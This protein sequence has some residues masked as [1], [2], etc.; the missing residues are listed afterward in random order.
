[1]LLIAD[2]LISHSL[3]QGKY[4]PA[5][6]EV[7][8]DI[9]DGKI[10]ADIAIYGSSRAWVHYDARLFENLTGVSAYNFGED[11]S[12]IM[13]QLIR[14]KEYIKN[15]QPPKLILLSVDM[16][17]IRKNVNT[18]PTE[19]YYPYML[20][21]TDIKR[22]L[23]EHKID[24]DPVLFWIPLL[25]YLKSKSLMQELFENPNDSSVIALGKY[26]VKLNEN[27]KV[28]DMGYRGMELTFNEDDYIR[29]KNELKDYEVNVDPI[30]IDVFNNF[31]VELKSLGIKIIM[32]YPPEYKKGQS[33]VSNRDD[34]ID[35]FDSIAMSNQ[36]QFYNYSD[37]LISNDKKY[38]YNVQHLNKEGAEIFTQSVVNSIIN[39]LKN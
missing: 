3:R 6:N 38:F 5:E 2:I 22:M 37:S 17:T 19:R 29:Q 21:K 14:H 8:N 4:F 33:I 18:Y 34:I 32:I 9:Y 27:G 23:V 30:I 25:R 1:M 36:V 35:K 24:F 28:R 26:E 20:F 31:I 12:N 13:I 7:W 10:K 11:G 16:W 39:P 15:N